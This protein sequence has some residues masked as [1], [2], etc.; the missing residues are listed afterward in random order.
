MKETRISREDFQVFQVRDW[1]EE[2]KWQNE[3]KIFVWNSCGMKMDKN[4][5]C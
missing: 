1:H 4:L 3:E 2:G 5:V